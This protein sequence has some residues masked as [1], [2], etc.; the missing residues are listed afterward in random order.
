MSFTQDFLKKTALVAETLDVASIE[1]MAALLAKV[2]ERGGRVFFV[3]SGGGAGH[4]SHAVCDFRKLGGF[5]PSAPRTMSPNSPPASTTRAGK[6]RSPRASNAAEFALETLCLFS[7]WE[8]AARRKTFPRI[9]S[10]RCAPQS[11][12]APPCSVSSDATAASPQR[13]PTPAPLCQPSILPS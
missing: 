10:T 11:L 1:K 5:K 4:A 2:R 13:M 9:W 8:A 3:G 6:P 12:L 7:Q